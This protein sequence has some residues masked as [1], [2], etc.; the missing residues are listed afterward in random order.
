MNLIFI[1]QQFHYVNRLCKKAAK[2]IAAK[3][4][5]T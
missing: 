5:S 3:N 4:K 2:K 1:M